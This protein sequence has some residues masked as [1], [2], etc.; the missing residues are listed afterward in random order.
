M[1]GVYLSPPLIPEQ[2]S[3]MPVRCV[4]INAR[5]RV[6]A[7]SHA[8]NP[9]CV[10]GR[11]C[12]QFSAAR[13]AV[14]FRSTQGTRAAIEVAGADAT[15]LVL[16]ADHDPCPMCRHIV[17]TSPGVARVVFPGGELLNHPEAS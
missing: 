11:G 17:A 4:I 7:S 15:T 8:G 3:A 13:P 9:G 16:L 12:P 5:H 10:T 1:T 14:W 2:F 6:V